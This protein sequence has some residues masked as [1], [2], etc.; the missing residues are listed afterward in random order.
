MKFTR[1]WLGD[2][3]ECEATAQELATRLT[4]LGLEVEEILDQ[5]AALAPFTVARVVEAKAHPDA[6]RLKVCTVE[7][8]DGTYQ[9]VCGAPNARTG[10]KGVF[11]PPGVARSRDGARPQENQDSWRR[12]Q[13]DAAFRT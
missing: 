8:V 5:A 3:L 4:A 11:A 1:A 2:H 12:V 7:T 6:D 10:M 9:V 13:R